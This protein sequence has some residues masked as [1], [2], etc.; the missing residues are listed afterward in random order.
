MRQAAFAL[1][2]G[3]SPDWRCE[4]AD[5]QIWSSDPALLATTLLNGV[6]GVGR[7]YGIWK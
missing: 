7:A 2:Y 3:R 1:K 5:A 4:Y 6:S